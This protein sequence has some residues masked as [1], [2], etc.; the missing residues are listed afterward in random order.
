MAKKI[1][2]V[3]DEPV[4]CAVLQRMLTKLDYHVVVAHNGVEATKILSHMDVDMVISDLRMPEMDGWELMRYVKK[5][6]PDLPV[7]LITGYHSMHTEAKATE[8]SADGY[9]S[10]PFSFIFCRRRSR[11]KSCPKMETPTLLSPTAFLT[12]P[13]H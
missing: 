5:S 10:K 3:D 8:H 2:V 6:L 9:I 11:G 7:I 1:L 4:L 13:A 12:T